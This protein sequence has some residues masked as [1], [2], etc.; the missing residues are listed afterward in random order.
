M[1]LPLQITSLSQLKEVI[2]FWVESY[3]SYYYRSDGNRRFLL[4][5]RDWHKNLFHGDIDVER[6]DYSCRLVG[7]KTWKL[8]ILGELGGVERMLLQNQ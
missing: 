7:G 4:R 3:R 8:H 1:R 5:Q 6:D 2:L